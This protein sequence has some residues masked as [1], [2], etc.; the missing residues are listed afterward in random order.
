MYNEIKPKC[1]HGKSGIQQ[2]ADSFHQQTGL[3]FKDITQ[4]IVHLEHHF[5]WC[6]NLDTSEYRS[7]MP[8]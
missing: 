5:V 4:A 7:E 3:T 2:E 1:C 6:L 8:F